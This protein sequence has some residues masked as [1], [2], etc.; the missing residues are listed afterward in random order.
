MSDTNVEEM[1]VGETEQNAAG[2]NEVAGS[3]GARLAGAGP[4]I[5]DLADG[6]G[7]PLPPTN[8][9]SP[10]P[11]EKRKSTKDVFING[12]K[13]ACKSSRKPYFKLET[14][15]KNKNKRS[16]LIMLLS[17]HLDVE[18]VRTKGMD[19][20]INNKQLCKDV[21]AHIDQLKF[22]YNKYQKLIYQLWIILIHS[23]HMLMMKLLFFSHAYHAYIYKICLKVH[24]ILNSY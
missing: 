23:S 5:V 15:Q 14:K 10:P 18:D 2:G 13:N 21:S 3:T 4:T 20:I 19:C 6:I 8:I 9:V 22:T 11:K 17:W 16:D 1:D 24:S 12:L 7:P